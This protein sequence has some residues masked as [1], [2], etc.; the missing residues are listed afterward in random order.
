MR[1]LLNAVEIRDILNEVSYKREEKPTHVIVD[2]ITT[3]TG[4]E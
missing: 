2:K 4:E 1:R 3:R